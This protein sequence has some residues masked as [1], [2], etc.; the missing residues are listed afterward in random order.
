VRI[1]FKK[2]FSFSVRHGKYKIGLLIEFCPAS[3]AGH[4]KNPKIEE[5][6]NH[7]DF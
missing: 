1:G 7:F 3:Q 4:F 6:F 5:I 2:R